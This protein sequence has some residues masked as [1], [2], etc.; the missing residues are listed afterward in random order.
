[1][2]RGIP[3]A[4]APRS[5]PA[6]RIAMP[7]H[8]PNVFAAC[9]DIHMNMASIFGWFRRSWPS[10]SNGAKPKMIFVNSMSDLFHDE[11]PDELHRRGRRDHAEGQLAHLSGS[12][13]AFGTDARPAAATQAAVRRASSHIWWGVS[14]ENRD[15]GLPRIDHLRSAPAWNPL[16]CRLNPCLKTSE[17]FDLAGIDWVIVGGESGRRARPMKEEWLRRLR[18]TCRDQGI[19]FFFKQ[20]GGVQKAKNGRTLDGRTYDEFPTVDCRP[21]RLIAHPRG[22]VVCNP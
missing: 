19:A 14:V 20:W 17:T 18:D 16:F 12:D 6:A 8:L 15:H 4:D 22:T 5:V 11:V 10:R 1:M 21:V 2:R 3:C 13:Q 9:R 7:R